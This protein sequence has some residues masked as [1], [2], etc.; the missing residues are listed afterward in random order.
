MLRR[1]IDQIVHCQVQ[2]VPKVLQYFSCPFIREAHINQAADL[3]G[4]GLRHLL[5]RI[6]Q[7][8]LLHNSHRLVCVLLQDAEEVIPRSKGCPIFVSLAEHLL[9]P[10]YSSNEFRSYSF[11]PEHRPLINR[12]LVE[13]IR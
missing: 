13:L 1:R 4:V 7:V 5:N 9:G 8:L 12:V 6:P 2:I 10:C 3:C 11:L